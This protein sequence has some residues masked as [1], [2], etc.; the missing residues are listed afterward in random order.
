MSNNAGCCETPAESWKIAII[1]RM[2]GAAY[3]TTLPILSKEQVRDRHTHTHITRS[4]H[5]WKETLQKKRSVEARLYN[6]PNS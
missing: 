1:L 4:G 5:F 6:K 2:Y 3:L